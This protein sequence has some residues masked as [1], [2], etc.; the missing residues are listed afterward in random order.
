MGSVHY[1]SP[2]QA[3]GGYSD[4]KS[5]VYSLGITLFEMLTGRVPFNGDTTVAIAIKHI[6]EEMPSPR[7]FVPEIPISVEKIVLKCT[8][9]SPDRRYQ[10]MGLLTDDLKRSLI[11]PEEDFVDLENYDRVGETKAISLAGNS[12]IR[13]NE[14]Q[15]A[16]RTEEEV[17]REDRYVPEKRMKKSAPI[18]HERTTGPAGR[19]QQG[20]SS[21][22]QTS[23]PEMVNRRSNT[24]VAS[25]PQNNTYQKNETAPQKKAD[26]KFDKTM[27]TISIALA[28]VIGVV[29]LYLVGSVLGIFG[30]NSNKDTMVTMPDVIDAEYTEAVTILE[31]MGLKV[32]IDFVESADVD[33]NRIIDTNVEEGE[34]VAVGTQVQITV[35]TGAA[36]VKVPSVVG[37]SLAEATS[38]LKKEGFVVSTV[39]AYS[40]EVSK[41][42]VIS[43]EPKENTKA[44]R[45]AEVVLTISAG[46]EEVF[47]S[48]PNVLNRTV[49][50]ARK[51]LVDA[52]YTVNS[53]TDT[54]SDEYAAGYICYQSFSEGTNV[55]QGT[56][57]DL[58]RS[59]GPNP[60][61]NNT[62]QSGA[63][64]YQFTDE[65]KAPTSVDYVYG[66]EVTVTVKSATGEQLWKTTTYTFPLTVNV[67]GIATDYGTVLLE[68]LVTG[69]A[70]TVTDPNT[71]EVTTVPGNSEVK[72]EERTV[73]FTLG[74]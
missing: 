31:N 27:I 15:K 2:E 39:E 18:I 55:K 63:G 25:N 3:R 10:S 62:S 60:E 38:T 73:Y 35:S 20:A 11:H 37:I 30:G 56:G 24:N 13:R 34:S 9:K 1:T 70:T 66:T 69:E 42:N 59:L 53:V 32:D 36:G 41:N 5:D 29:I 46:E 17:T 6:Q 4:E 71:G 74:E 12:T 14:Q 49:D 67:T 65:I 64:V 48:M 26:N 47:S 68:Y 51:M 54:Y 19:G 61:G 33:A 43:Q 72:T 22:Q 57:V 7:E 44:T 50:E 16:K 28:V 40:A 23:R 8:Q 45:G 58:K 21:N 52:G